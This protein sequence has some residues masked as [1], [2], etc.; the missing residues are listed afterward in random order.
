M[1][2]Y[3]IKQNGKVIIDGPVYVA[4]SFLDRFFGLMGRKKID[5]EEGL[6]LK[7]TSSIHTSFMKFTID[8]IYL[9]KDYNV[10][11]KE[12]VKPWR[13][14]KIVK[15]C[16]HVIELNENKKDRFQLDKIEIEKR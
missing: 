13:V 9:N 6:L 4:N 11:Y 3:R 7:N 14:G 5:E 12:T 2:C 10:I 16:K 1:E 8:V 15:G